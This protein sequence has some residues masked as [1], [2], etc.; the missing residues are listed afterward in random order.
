MFLKFEKNLYNKNL[1]LI[2]AGLIE[3]NQLKNEY[4]M[5]FSEFCQKEFEDFEKTY[6]A[7]L[8]EHN[9]NLAT[10]FWKNEIEPKYLRSTI[11]F[12]S[13]EEFKR[14]YV[15]FKNDFKYRAFEF[16]T[17]EKDL[18][19]TQFNNKINY[20]SAE[21]KIQNHIDNERIK[22]EYNNRIQALENQSAKNQ[23]VHSNKQ[24]Q[25]QFDHSYL[26]KNYALS[27]CVSKPDPPVCSAVPSNYSHTAS[28][29]PVSKNVLYRFASINIV[30]SS[31]VVYP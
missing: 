8:L 15:T 26:Q 14:S 10:N 18:F 9:L 16:D 1:S 17:L 31:D 19:W 30:S 22:N 29:I 28:S 12:K 23:N 4:R 13:I 11:E 6:K 7:T 20:N 5:K 2:E 24:S 21:V 3:V 25:N 27:T